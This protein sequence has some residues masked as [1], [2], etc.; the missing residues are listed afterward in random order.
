VQARHLL[1]SL[2]KFDKHASSLMLVRYLSPSHTLLRHDPA[3][4]KPFLLIN[5][6]G[7]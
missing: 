3:A 6:M 5:G 7:G 4:T 2:S 1:E